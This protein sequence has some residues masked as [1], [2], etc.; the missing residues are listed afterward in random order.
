MP[1]TR[2]QEKPTGVGP[3][4]SRCQPVMLRDG[5]HRF[6]RPQVGQQHTEHPACCDEN[7]RLGLVREP[8]A[9]GLVARVDGGEGTECR[10]DR[11]IRPPDDQQEQQGHGHGQGDADG[12]DVVALGRWDPEEFCDLTRR[13]AL[14]L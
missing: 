6:R 5:H 8:R 12:R 4:L 13:I 1:A 7:P 2:G 9:D 14:V 10:V 3:Q 11:Q